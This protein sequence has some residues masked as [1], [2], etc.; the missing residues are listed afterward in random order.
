M[1]DDHPAWRV[2]AFCNA[3]RPPFNGHTVGAHRSG[4]T[5]VG[6]LQVRLRQAPG[7]RVPSLEFRRGD[8]VL[9]VPPGET[10]GL[11]P[12]MADLLR[13]AGVRQ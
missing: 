1:V 8:A 11:A 12:A 3:G 4:V 2:S 10:A 7:E 9:V 6:L 13:A 5:P